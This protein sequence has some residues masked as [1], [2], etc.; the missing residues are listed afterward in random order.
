MQ[1]TT[2]GMPKTFFVMHFAEPVDVLFLPVN[3]HILDE[4]CGLWWQSLVVTNGAAT[5]FEGHI[6]LDKICE[7]KIL[8]YQVYCTMKHDI[9]H[10]LWF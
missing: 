6:V 1:E 3:E 4:S 2:S 8:L 5:Y 7:L 10:K 9:N